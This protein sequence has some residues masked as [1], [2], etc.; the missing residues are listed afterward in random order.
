M[1]VLP[2]GAAGAQPED[3]DRRTDADAY[4]GKPMLVCCRH[5]GPG[6]SFT[7]IYALM[8][9]YHREP[10]IVL[11]D[12]LAWDPAIDVLL[13]RLPARFISPNPGAGERHRGAR[14]PSWPPGLD[15]NDAFVIFP[16]GGNFT[17]APPRAGHRAAAQAACTGWPTA[18]RR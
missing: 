14:S 3:R 9:W 13:R 12:T 16:E 17:A 18:P 1:G 15:E 11:K 6:D 10:R 7:L 2:R 5:A 4:P 8:H